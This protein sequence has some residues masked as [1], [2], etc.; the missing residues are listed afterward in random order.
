M[1]NDSSLVFLA[2][3]WDFEIILLEQ[4]WMEIE[5]DIDFQFPFMNISKISFS[6]N[7]NFFFFYKKWQSRFFFDKYWSH[8]GGSYLP[9]A[10]FAKRKQ[11]TNA[12]V[13]F[14]SYFLQRKMIIWLNYWKISLGKGKTDKGNQCLKRQIC[15]YCPGLFL[16]T[17]NLKRRRA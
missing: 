7:L 5:P 3:L 2:R 10:D 6:V 12:M 11:N 13:F 17:V 9:L 1:E 8:V 15:I 4:D 14:S 16:D